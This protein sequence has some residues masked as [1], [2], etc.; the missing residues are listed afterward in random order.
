MA[1]PKIALITYQDQGKYT[2]T[3]EDEDTVLFNFLKNKGLDLTF[4][5]WNNPEVN[6]DNYH[7]LILKS[8]WDYFDYIIDFREWLDAIE[9]KNIPMLNP[10]KTVRWNTD[11]HYLREIEAAGFTITPTLWIEPGEAFKLEQIFRHY[12]TNQIIIKPC[13]SGGAK[14]TFAISR[15]NAEEQAIKLNA[16]FA[17]ESFLAQ[18]FLPEVQTQGEWSFIFFKGRFSHCLLKTPQPGDFRVQHYLGGS[19]FPTEPPAHL[20]VEASGIVQQF[21]ADC[22]YARVDGLEVNGAFMLME[23]EL[24]EP[25]LFLFT[26]N[27]S[28]DNYYQALEQLLKSAA[29]KA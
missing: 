17:Q 2:S 28:L 18:P 13:V 6:W 20:L 15:E 10:L 26:H 4:E 24:I 25:F 27:A 11:K 14:N 19:I 3:V 5:V 16:L 29:L 22:L 8:P 1:S 7:L 12:G 23:L 9:Q 21:A